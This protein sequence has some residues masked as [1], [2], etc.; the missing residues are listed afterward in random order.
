MVQWV[1]RHT[2][3][4]G[5]SGQIPAQGTRGHAATKSLYKTTEKKKNILHSTVKI[6]DPAY[7]NW[8]Q[9]QLNKSK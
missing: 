7:G 1:K 8:N 6:R 9:G 3:N 2:P 5:D 4:A